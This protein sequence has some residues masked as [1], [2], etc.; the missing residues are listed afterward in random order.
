MKKTENG[1]KETT[2]KPEEFSITETKEEEN[3]KEEVV[4]NVNAANK[5]SK[6]KKSRTLYSPQLHN[7]QTTRTQ[8][9]V[10]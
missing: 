10:F 2:R 4:N 1:V 9:L 5:S 3:F 8:C 6:K 7:L